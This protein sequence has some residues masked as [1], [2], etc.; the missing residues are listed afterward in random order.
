LI[1]R[2]LLARDV[3]VTGERGAQ[4]EVVG[5]ALQRGFV[6]VAANLRDSMG[7]DGY[8]ALLARALVRT[9]A[10]H[11]ALHGIRGLNDGNFHLDGVVASVA[12]HGVSEVTEAVEALLAALVDVLSRLIGE[13][14]AIRILEASAPRSQN[15]DRAAP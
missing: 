1:A 11:P 14:M 15:G 12:A 4:P 8:H 5:A 3:D 9:R 10:H 7:E 6:R 13:D 2:R